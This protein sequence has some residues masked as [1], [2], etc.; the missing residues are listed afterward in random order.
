MRR[1]LVANRGEIAVRIVRACRDEGISPVAVYSD[2]DRTARHVRLADAAVLVGEP[3]SSQSYLRADRIIEAAKAT[4]CDAVHPGYGFLSENDLF[5]Q[6][7]MEAG[8]TWVGPPPSAIKTMG[9]KASARAAAIAAGVPVV[10]GTEP[11]QDSEAAAAAARIGYPVLVKA[12]A[13][14]GG[15]GMRRVGSAGELADALTAARGEAARSF[16]NDALYIEKFLERP[17]HV[18]IQVFGGPDGRSIHLGERDCSTQRRHQK[19]VEESPS[20]VVSPE[21]RERMGRVAV[22]AADAVSYVGAGTCEFL[23]DPDDR[24]ASG[25]PRF[26]FLEMNTRLQVEH[27]VTELVTGLDLVRLQLAVARGEPLPLRQADV[28]LAGHAIECR[29][30]AED[31]SAGFAPSPGRL[32]AF[33]PPDGPGIRCDS[34]VTD[35]DEISIHYDP[36][37]AKLLAHGRDRAE[38]IARMKRALREFAIGGVKTSVPFHLHLLDLPEFVRGEVHV[39]FVDTAWKGRLAELAA[40]PAERV[41]I[42][43]A[44]AAI[45]ELVRARR[46]APRHAG[47]GKDRT[48]WRDAGRRQIMERLP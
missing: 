19:L 14:G 13:G 48:A 36:M 18:E 28:R 27:P 47:N 35:G 17:R 29:V 11:L 9:D 39:N 8:L 4:G 3:P 21:L 31:P 16:G 45:D 15:K 12:V 33:T 40:A 30:Y 44:V 46:G 37:V 5:A 24:D 6:R 26:Y 43:V 42:A 10:P 34:G 23:V 20:P 41:P 2:A 32:V 7:V 22:Q 25:E 1:L 38:A